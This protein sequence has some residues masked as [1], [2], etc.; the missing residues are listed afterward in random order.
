M[1]LSL[2][3]FVSLLII[4][5]F[6]DVQAQNLVKQTGTRN[7]TGVLN[8]YRLPFPDP[9]SEIKYLDLDG[10]GDPDVLKATVNGFPVQWIDDDDD[11]KQGDL[12]GDT[13]SDCLMVDRNKDGNYGSYEDVVVDWVDHNDDNKADMQ[14]YAEYAGE[15]Q[16]DIPWGPGHLMICMDLDQDNIMNYIDWNTFDLRGWLHDGQSDFYEDYLGKSLFLKIH[17]SP[18]KMND[19]RL[20]WENPFLFYDPDRD[21]LSEYAIR[22]IDNPE[23]GNPGDLYLT[24]LTG[25]V[26]WISMS[27]DLDNDN[28]P[29]NEFDFDMTV[30]FRGKGFNYMDQ[31]HRFPRMRGLPESD[32]F[33]MDPRVRRLTELIYPDHESIKDLVFKRG[34]WDQVYFVYDEDDDCNRWERVELYDPKDP[35]RTGKRNGGL[36]D[37]PQSDVVGDRGE[38]DLDNSGKGNLYVSK[39]DGK[40]HLYGAESGYWRVDQNAYYFQGMGGLYDGY[41]PERLS[42]EVKNPFPLVKYT[43]TDG[44]GFF[45]RVEYDLDGDQA[46]DEVVS[47]LDLGIDDRSAVIETASM[48]YRDFTA[49]KTKVAD[50]MWQQAQM[51]VKVASQAGINVQWYALL[52]HPRSVRQ[53]YHMGYWLQFYLYRDLKELAIRNNNPAMAETLTKGYFSGNW[54]SIKLNN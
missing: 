12:Q 29:G 22:V 1:K 47:L 45:D 37:N 39:L 19:L 25:N 49:L 28:A 52:M 9:G 15:N 44:N 10:D 46:A 21:G 17:T 36:D 4:V 34:E 20:N 54:K 11:M 16:K 53:K 26:S 33:F 41:G 30:S 7:S 42:R 35:Y 43:D 48:D 14:I 2:T 6:G 51:A 8:P 5:R 23:K 31:V 18:E 40:I 13:D 32:R 27:Y 24:R 3:L 38:W 50:G